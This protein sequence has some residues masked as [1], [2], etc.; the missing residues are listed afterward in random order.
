M[1]PEE[2]KLSDWMRILFGDVP[3][4][5]YAELIIRAFL[6]YALLMISMRLM[7]TRM[8][9]QLSRLDLAAMVAL[10]SAIGVPILSPVNGLLPAFIIAFIVVAM[11]RV[12]AKLSFKNQHFEQVTQDD[13]DVLVEESVMQP[14]I[15][16]RTR[17]SRERLFAQLRSGKVSHL[18][19]VKRV[20]LEAGGSFSIIENE[21]SQPG[22]MVLPEW[23]ED[24]IDDTLKKTDIVVCR[25]CGEKKPDN[26]PANKST[27]CP[28]CGDADWTRASIGKSRL[29]INYIPKF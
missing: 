28:H 18:G 16:K 15:L 13:I 22:L 20:Y 29:Q 12:I 26:A 10:A 6:V 2:I 17:I 1:K 19:K 27:K 3:P 25:N 8:S 21:D 23:D 9:G 4:E 14:E 7:G 5:F 11:S 24:F